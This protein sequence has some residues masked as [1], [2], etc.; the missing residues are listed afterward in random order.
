MSSMQLYPLFLLVIFSMLA[1][2][3]QNDGSETKKVYPRTF[4]MGL[5]AHGGLEKWNASGT[6][7]FTEGTGEDLTHYTVDLKNRN[8]L[9]ENPGHYRVGFTTDSIYYYPNRDSFPSKN[10]RF[11]HN[12]RFYFFALPYV[13][14]DPGAIQEELEPAALNGI[15]YDRVKVTFDEGVGVAPKDQYIL[16]Y[17]QDTHLL[18][19]INYSVTYFDEA[20][21]ENYSAIRYA[22]WQESGGLKFPAEM[23]GYKWENDSLGEERY[24]R[25]FSDIVIE[26][27]RPAPETFIDLQ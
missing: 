15:M 10:P 1:C 20:N 3:V 21:A 6:L 5:T 22:K 17:D 7:K 13:T 11:M 16:W 19:F 2:S 9:I 24:R 23:I 25:K 14:A 26:N 18:T 4:A 27:K 12:L 8:E